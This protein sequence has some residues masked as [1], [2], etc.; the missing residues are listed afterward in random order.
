MR[1]AF[2][3]EQLALKAEARRFLE[4]ERH[5][6][7]QRLVEMGWPGLAIP[8]RYGGSGL[9][10]VEWCAVSE[11]AGRVLLSAPL[12]SSVIA[13]DALLQGGTEEQRREHL[14]ALA[15][16]KRRASLVSREGWALDGMTADLFLFIDGLDG[17]QLAEASA[18]SR[19][20]LTTLDETRPLA[21]VKLEGPSQP[22][23]AKPEIVERIEARA[24]IALAAEQVGGAERCLEMSVAYAKTRH[25]FGRPIGSFQ[26]IKHMCADMLVRV[27]SARSAC[28]WAGWVAAVDDPELPL[29]ASLAKAWC[30]EAFFKNAGENIQIHGGIGF[31]W[32]HD[33]HLYFRRARS[34]LSQFGDPTQHRENVARRIGL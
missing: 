2:S 9:G 23:A 32:E 1:F 15:V 18:V 17:M 5:P 26:A 8:E 30:S 25:Q 20:P 22:M 19:S 28:Y 10:W 6:A 29:A 12:F 13:A 7:W 11:E 21:A 31:T 24:A 3:E 27:E 33:A 4:R 16:G 34:S 14:P